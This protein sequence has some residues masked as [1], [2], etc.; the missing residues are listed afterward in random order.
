[1]MIVLAED[2]K[3]DLICNCLHPLT[4][5]RCGARVEHIACPCRPR[6]TVADTVVLLLL[7]RLSVRVVLCLCMCGVNCTLYAISLTVLFS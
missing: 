7:D 3:F 2:W 1:M 5:H 4:L 6:V